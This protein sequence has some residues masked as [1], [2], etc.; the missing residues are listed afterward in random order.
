MKIYEIDAEIERLLSESVDEETG[1]LLIDPE[2]LDALQMERDRKVEN[3]AL[4]Y[5]NL[6]AD[7]DA[8]Q[9]E[10]DILKKEAAALEGRVKTT[11]N[12]AK[13]AASYLMY[14]LK[15]EKFKTPKV[16]V[17]FGTSQSVKIDDGFIEWAMVSAP[18]YL[19]YKLPEADKVAIKKAIE[20]G[21]EIF[22]CS[23]VKNDTI[24]IR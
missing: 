9:A 15:G 22:G 5:K 6:L 10:A 12:A 3:L 21:E 16:S 2:K 11:K 23:I 14:V 4:V 7:A 17:S 13:K 19:R 20:S 24:K 1:E 8:I 18:E